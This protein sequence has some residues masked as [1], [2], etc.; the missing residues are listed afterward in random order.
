M[1]TA[2]RVNCAG[3]SLPRTV[4]YTDDRLHRGHLRNYLKQKCDNWCR[5]LEEK[6]RRKTQDEEFQ[7]VA[8]AFSPL[9]ESALMYRLFGNAPRFHARESIGESGT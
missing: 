6:R 5:M 2:V 3:T 1:S 8:K 9:K 4:S 7:K